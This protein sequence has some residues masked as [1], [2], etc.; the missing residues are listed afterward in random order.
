MGVYR[1]YR[2]T[3]DISNM[4]KPQSRSPFVNFKGLEYS[5]V[6]P[7][8][9]A[10]RKDGSFLG[11]QASGLSFHL[12]R[13]QIFI[14]I[15][16]FHCISHTLSRTSFTL[17]QISREFFL[18]IGVPTIFDFRLFFERERCQHYCTPQFFNCHIIASSGTFTTFIVYIFNR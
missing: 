12:Y 13:M 5:N 4:Y 16:R 8:F 9:A 1:R 11:P 15:H 10:F 17:C 3:P 14:D 7:V 18:L 2:T 6:S